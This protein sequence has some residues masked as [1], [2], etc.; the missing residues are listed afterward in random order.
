MKVT[1]ANGE[2]PMRASDLREG[3]IFMR[4]DEEAASG[5]RDVI[6]LALGPRELTGSKTAGSRN[7]I[8]LDGR[9]S[10][11]A[12]NI[13]FYGYRIVQKVVIDEVKVSLVKE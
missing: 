6:Y 5:C 2:S 11:F 1:I 12:R 3:D 13:W 9:K 10:M 7:A 4:A 8:E